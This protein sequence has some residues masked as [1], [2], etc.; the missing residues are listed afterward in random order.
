[1][2]LSVRVTALVVVAMLLA[3]A[4]E[5]QQERNI[6]LNFLG[7]DKWKNGYF[8][9]PANEGGPGLYRVGLGDFDGKCLDR[10]QAGSS[11]RAIIQPN[12]GDFAI[13]YVFVEHGTQRIH[14]LEAP[15][16]GLGC[17]PD[18]GKPDKCDPGSHWELN[19]NAPACKPGPDP[20]AWIADDP[21]QQRSGSNNAAAAQ[22]RSNAIGD[23][24]GKRDKD[25]GRCVNHRAVHDRTLLVIIKVQTAPGRTWSFDHAPALVAER[26]LAGLN[27]NGSRIKFV[28][29][30]GTPPDYIFTITLNQTHE[31]TNQNDAF[32][33]VVGAYEDGNGGE[34]QDAGENFS[35]SSGK[36]PYTSWQDA[37]DHLAS[38]TVRWFVEGWHN[39]PPCKLSNGLVRRN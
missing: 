33:T 3:V 28:E 30:N 11:Y 27:D 34:T 8:V 32:L 15:A 26:F 29:P 13:F 14:T 19:N 31:G 4:I 22:P 24:P 18:F 5:A 1:M 16:G 39:D 36:S 7:M 12:S 6:T 25:L 20:I 23:K 37:I 17:Y 38:N 2:R 10:F 35:E 9:D 21:S